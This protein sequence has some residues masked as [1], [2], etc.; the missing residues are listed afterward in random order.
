MSYPEHRLSRLR[1]SAVLREMVAEHRF[2][3]SDLIQPLFIHYGENE[4]LVFVEVTKE[5]QEIINLEQFFN[6]LDFLK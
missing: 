6:T 2:S 5:G 4:K 3:A 1:G